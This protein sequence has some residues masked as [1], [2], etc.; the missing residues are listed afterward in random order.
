MGVVG[1]CEP[2]TD[3]PAADKDGRFWLLPLAIGV[4]RLV[5][6]FSI[7]LPLTTRLSL[8]FRKSLVIIS[9]KVSYGYTQL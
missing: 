9:G 2:F 1:V 3:G 7:S 5:D 6:R 8:D 4:R